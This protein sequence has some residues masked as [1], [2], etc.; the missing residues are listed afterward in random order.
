VFRRATAIMLH[1]FKIWFSWHFQIQNN[2]ARITGPDCWGTTRMKVLL[3]A[4]G[5]MSFTSLGKRVQKQACHLS[6]FTG[7][8][9]FLK[10]FEECLNKAAVV[11][12]REWNIRIARRP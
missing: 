6:A 4:L 10:I 2:L 12:R 8:T 7:I 3:I 1:Y 11:I 5:L 9:E